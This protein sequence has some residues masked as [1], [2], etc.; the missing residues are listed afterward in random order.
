[1]GNSSTATMKPAT[2]DLR[3]GE[4]IDAASFK[5]LIR[6]AVVAYAAARVQRGGKKSET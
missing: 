2:S 1:M 4:A 3:E 5:T 6:A